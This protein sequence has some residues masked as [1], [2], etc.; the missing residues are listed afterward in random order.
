M[1]L[2]STQLYQLVARAVLNNQ[3][4]LQALTVALD[5]DDHSLSNFMP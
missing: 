4:L 1:F 3:L 2:E 5:C